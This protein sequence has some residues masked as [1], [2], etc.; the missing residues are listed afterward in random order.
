MRG[1]SP[2]APPRGY[3][4]PHRP[5]AKLQPRPLPRHVARYDLPSKCLRVYGLRD[6]PKRLLNLHCLKENYRFTNSLPQACRFQFQNR[7]FGRTG[8]EPVC[9]RER[10][11]RIVRG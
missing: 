7:Y 10:G 5:T 11:Y 3:P 2:W 9:L 4:I 1:R 6:G 8:Y